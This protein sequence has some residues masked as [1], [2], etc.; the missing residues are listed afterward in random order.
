LE[1]ARAAALLRE[2]FP[3]IRCM[4]GVVSNELVIDGRPSEVSQVCA[5]VSR[6]DLP[7]PQVLIESKVVEVSSSGLLNLGLRYSF[8][9]GSVS[10]VLEPE[11]DKLKLGSNISVALS[12]LQSAGEADVLA[13]P[14]LLTLNG[15]PAKIQIGSKVPYA[16]PVQSGSANVLWQVE[17]IDSGVKLDI[18]PKV[19]AHGYIQVEI[20]PE[21]S[22][23]SEWRVT[24]AGEFPVITTRN[25]KTKVRVRDGETIVI[26]GLL[27]R[28]DRKTNTAVPI[29]SALPVLGWFFQAQNNQ[30]E[31]SEIVFMITPHLVG[32]DL[33][34]GAKKK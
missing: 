33:P 24:A 21:V 27:S 14:N 1:S 8:S 31:K 25:V 19:L 32:A 12:A 23:I 28:S 26:G 2:I 20:E 15:V 18:T 4:E 3:K 11:S 6:L 17:Y 22:A 5:F 10:C 30:N 29:L 16:V 7:V 34:D 13:T 9:G